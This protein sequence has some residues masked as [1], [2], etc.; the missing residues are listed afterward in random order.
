MEG[1]NSWKGRMTL[2]EWKALGLWTALFASSIASVCFH[3][4]SA[5]ESSFSSSSLLTLLWEGTSEPVPSSSSSTKSM[6]L[7]NDTV[8]SN[9]V[10]TGCWSFSLFKTPWPTGSG[11]SWEGDEEGSLI[12]CSCQTTNSRTR[13]VSISNVSAAF[14]FIKFNK[15]SLVV[16]GL[17]SSKSKFA[18]KPF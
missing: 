6:A 12:P 4:S 17:L 11:T 8:P 3:N 18:V 15:T 2:C 10:P 14:L 5:K 13:T 9:D 7:G 16:L 1:R